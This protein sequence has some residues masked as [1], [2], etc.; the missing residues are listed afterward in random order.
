MARGPSLNLA[1]WSRNT[2]MLVP[3]LDAI[4]HILHSPPRIDVHWTAPDINGKI[5]TTSGFRTEGLCRLECL[6]TDSIAVE[7][8]QQLVGNHL[9][10]T[11]GPYSVGWEL[12]CTASA[13]DGEQLS[14]ARSGV[15]VLIPALGR[16]DGGSTRSATMC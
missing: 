8:V 16:R 3:Q 6:T 14:S 5:G 4:I 10:W 2:W 15:A 7:F 1:S 11:I 13:Q 9:W 12:V